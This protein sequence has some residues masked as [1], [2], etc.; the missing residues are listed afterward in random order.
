MTLISDRASRILQTHSEKGNLK[1]SEN[2]F[3]WKYGSDF[4]IVSALGIGGRPTGWMPNFSWTNPWG[5][6]GVRAERRTGCSEKVPIFLALMVRNSQGKV[7]C[8]LRWNCVQKWKLISPKHQ[9]I[10]FFL[11]YIDTKIFRN[12]GPLAARCYCWS[13]TLL[14]AGC[15]AGLHV[16]EREKGQGLIPVSQLWQGTGHDGAVRQWT[17]AACFLLFS[18]WYSCV[19]NNESR[20]CCYWTCASRLGIFIVVNTLVLVNLSQKEMFWSNIDWPTGWKKQ[21]VKD[22]HQ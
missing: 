16:H 18:C 19:G 10:C 6:V 7:V 13:H 20:R 1:A 2:W 9:D 15:K 8:S 3:W 5:A 12:L 17:P 21:L 22:G 14:N 11:S 4:R